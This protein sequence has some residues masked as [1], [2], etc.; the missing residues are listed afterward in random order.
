MQDRRFLADLSVKEVIGTDERELENL[1]QQLNMTDLQP[2]VF[3]IAKDPDGRVYRLTIIPRLIEIPQPKRFRADDLGF[4]GWT[5]NQSAVILNDQDYIGSIGM[6]TD[7]FSLCYVNIPGVAVVDFSLTEF[8]GSKPIGTL[9]NGVISIEHES[10]VLQIRGVLNGK[11]PQVLEGPYQVFVRWKPSE[12]SLE[13]A[14][15]M[16]QA[17]LDR[18]KTKIENGDSSLRPEVLESLQNRMDSDRVFIMHSGTRGLQK[19]EIVHP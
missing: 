19:S 1:S 6:S 10:N 16:L 15:A 14:R 18:L 9:Q 4:D 12:Q 17:Q 2:H 5:F 13:D 3:E 8:T 7:G 11:I